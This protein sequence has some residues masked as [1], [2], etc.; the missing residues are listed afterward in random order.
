MV[1]HLANTRQWGG[2]ATQSGGHAVDRL[3]RQDLRYDGVVMTDDL[4]MKAIL[5][6]KPPAA[7][8]VD[9][10]KAGAD[11]IMFTK[12]SDEDQTSDVGRDINAALTAAVC[13]G[14]LKAGA[15]QRSVAR[16]R[17]WTSEWTQH[18]RK[19]AKRHAIVAGR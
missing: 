1:G 11:I 19:K 13:S 5:D 17:T 9:A 7:A 8:A 6:A 14:E 12:F 15:L 2:V 3:L 18:G 10:V 16:I 4:A